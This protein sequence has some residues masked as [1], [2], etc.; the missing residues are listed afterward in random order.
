MGVQV[1]TNGYVSLATVDLSDHGTT[2]ELS[3]SAD[4]QETTAF[5]SGKNRAYAGGLKQATCS[6]TFRQDFASGKVHATLGTQV[7]ETIAVALRAENTTISSTNPEYQF[8][9]VVTGYSPVSGSIGNTLDTQVTLQVTGAIT[10]DT[11]P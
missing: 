9:A 2:V 5:N 4:A 1:F 6:I 3:R 11:T 8:N 10:E 7:G